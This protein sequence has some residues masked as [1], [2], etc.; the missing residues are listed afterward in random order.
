MSSY[1]YILSRYQDLQKMRTTLKQLLEKAPPGSLIASPRD[2]GQCYYKYRIERNK[3]VYLKSS[4]HTLANRLAAKAV[5]KH[6]LSDIEKEIRAIEAYLKIFDGKNSTD[7]FL[8]KHPAHK[9]LAEEWGASYETFGTGLL[10]NL[11]W[12]QKVKN[13]DF[14]YELLLQQTAKDTLGNLSWKYEPDH[15]TADK[16]EDRTVKTVCGIKVR[17]KSEAIYADA[18]YNAGL[19]FIYEPE[20]KANGKVYHPDFMIFHPYTG[21][22]IIFEYLGL[23]PDSNE[24]QAPFA[25]DPVIQN[26][27]RY[28]KKNSEKIKNYILEGFLPGKTLICMSETSSYPVDTSLCQK[29]IQCFFSE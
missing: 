1:D 10:K 28:Q 5:R 7:E 4:E 29:V 12:I 8:K 27:I 21:G 19:L 20:Y 3:P 17:S 25:F 14:A 18:F 24:L 26:K 11:D 22:L 2:N 15:P 6:K 13:N 9:Q 16:Q 23:L